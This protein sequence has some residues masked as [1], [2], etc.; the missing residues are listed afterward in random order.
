MQCTDMSQSFVSATEI[1]SI[2]R[3]SSTIKLQP[4]LIKLD[5][6]VFNTSLVIKKITN[7][8]EKNWQHSMD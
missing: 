2:L 7:S 5:S 8:V 1:F 3:V 4:V 6:S